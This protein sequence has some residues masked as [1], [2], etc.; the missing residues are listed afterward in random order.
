MFNLKTVYAQEKSRFKKA[1]QLDVKSD[2][3]ERIAIA[4]SSGQRRVAGLH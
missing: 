4:S 1:A 2:L 3:C